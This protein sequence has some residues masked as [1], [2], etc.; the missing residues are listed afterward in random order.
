MSGHSKWNNIKNK[1]GAADAKRGK[2]FAQLSKHIRIAVKT[3][4]GGDVNSNPSLRL[5]VE[6]ARS[7]NM[8]NENIQR[9]IDRGLGIG[10]G[11]QIEEILYEGYGPAGVGFLVIAQTD[12]KMRTGSE[13]RSAFDKN[14]GSLGGPGSAM[15]LFQRNGDEYSVQI[16]LPLGS[17]Q[18]KTAV[19]RLEEALQEIDD[20]EE[21]FH[22]GK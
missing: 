2:I 22:N 13:I 17:E 21:I 16:P 4:G 14:G 3:G 8:P 6:K 20:V 5:A 1:K 19:E 10:K 15:Y 9:A 7:A 11:G 18:D 12:N